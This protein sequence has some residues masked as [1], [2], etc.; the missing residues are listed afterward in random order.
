MLL[1]YCW[2]QDFSIGF[3]NMLQKQANTKKKKKKDNPNLV[4][5]VG[6]LGTMKIK[7]SWPDFVLEQHLTSSG[8]EKDVQKSGF[9]FC[10]ALLTVKDP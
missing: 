1:G 3:I 7:G 5:C 8:T 9:F 4:H 10:H 2:G 6:E